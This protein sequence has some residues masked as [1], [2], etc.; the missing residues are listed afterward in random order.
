M[1]ITTIEKLR[2]YISRK[3]SLPQRTVYHVISAL[4][5][6]PKGSG[7]DFKELSSQL[8][9]Y[10]DCSDDLTVSEFIGGYDTIT[11]IK[12]NRA[13]IVSHMEH[14][15]AALGTDIFSMVQNSPVVHNSKKPSPSEIW[16]G[17]YGDHYRPELDTIYNV[18]AWYTL[19]VISETWNEYLEKHLSSIKILCT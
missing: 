19:K 3:S 11:L 4:D 9:F 7:D 18:L 15:A 5:F 2:V 6:P 10:G 17:F 13:A 16:N 8:S 12:K 1:L 14:T